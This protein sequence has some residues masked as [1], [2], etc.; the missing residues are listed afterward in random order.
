M[1]NNELA[2]LSEVWNN[3]DVNVGINTK[4]PT[5]YFS[6]FSVVSLCLQIIQLFFG[7]LSSRFLRSLPEMLK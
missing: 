7:I 1:I 6:I 2:N 4:Q 5:F 3:T